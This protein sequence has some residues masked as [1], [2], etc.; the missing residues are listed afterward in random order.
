[1]TAEWAVIKVIAGGWIKDIEG[2]LGE[3]SGGALAAGGGHGGDGVGVGAV[4]YGFMYW[5][6]VIPWNWG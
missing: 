6:R 4:G 2:P 1:M 3:K 5:G